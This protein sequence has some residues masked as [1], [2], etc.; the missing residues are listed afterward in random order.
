MCAIIDASVA[1]LIFDTGCEN[2]EAAIKFFDRVQN[3][4]LRIVT[5][6][7][8]KHERVIPYKRR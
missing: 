6:G 2:K 8:K 3:D 7:K 1:S 5:G 4:K